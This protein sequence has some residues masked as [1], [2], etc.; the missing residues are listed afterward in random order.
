M[1]QH[2]ILARLIWESFPPELRG[3][4]IRAIAFVLRRTED[5]PKTIERAMDPVHVSGGN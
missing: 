5:Q 1:M 4:G 3:A 2:C